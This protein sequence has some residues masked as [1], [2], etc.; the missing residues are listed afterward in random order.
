[1]T[2]ADI[3]L[4]SNEDDEFSNFDFSQI[5]RIS[6][7][8]TKILKMDSNSINFIPKLNNSK[9]FNDFNLKINDFKTEQNLEIAARYLKETN[10]PIAFPTES[11]YGLAASSFSTKSI[12]NIYKIKNRPSDNPLIS[13]VSSIEMLKEQLFDNQ[14]IPQI[15]L[16]LIEKF[17]PGPLSILL[18]IPKNSKLSSATTVGQPTF[19]VRMPS[20]PIARALIKL[21]NEPIAAPSSNTSTKPST[22]TAQHVYHDLHGKIPAIL[23]GG[24][25]S[26]GVESTVIDGLSSPPMLLRPGCITLEQIKEVGGKE[27]ENIVVFKRAVGKDEPVKTP[28]MKYRHYSPDAKVVL[29]DGCGNG[30]EKILEYIKTLDIDN[31]NIKDLK[32]ALLK[33]K[34]FES[35]PEIQQYI[36]IERDLGKSNHDIAQNLF[37]EL[38]EMDDLGMNIILVEGVTE[39]DEGLAIMNRL[40]KASSVIIR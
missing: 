29:F 31:K 20:N 18:P 8:N 38:R 28:G 9:K 12:H 30:K 34:F 7:L 27:W 16:K 19:A 17:W 4:K 24:L 13:H 37:Y 23:D 14:E 40:K 35:I 15:Y 11:V 36:S 26:V 25:C 21:T 33:S 1:M 3:N 39:E 2:Q 10:Q 22:T 6:N 5:D 32:I